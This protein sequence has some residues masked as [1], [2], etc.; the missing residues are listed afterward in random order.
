MHNKA[1]SDRHVCLSDKTN[2]IKTW[3]SLPKQKRNLD[4]LLNL[5]H[6]FAYC[7]IMHV[8]GIE[9][10]NTI[11]TK[12]NH[13]IISLQKLFT[14]GEKKLFRVLLAADHIKH[15]AGVEKFYQP[16]RKLLHEIILGSARLVMTDREYR[17][18]SRRLYKIFK[19]VPG[20]GL[21]RI[22]LQAQ[23]QCGKT[24]TAVFAVYLI[25]MFT[26]VPPAALF[27][28][29]ISQQQSSANKLLDRIQ[30][31]SSQFSSLIE[32]NP[33]LLGTYFGIGHS[34]NSGEIV[35]PRSKTN[36]K[37]ISGRG[38]QWEFRALPNSADACRSWTPYFTLFDEYG[39]SDEDVRSVVAGYMNHH[40]RSFV[41]ITTPA[42]KLSHQWYI[43]QLQIARDSQSR[44][45]GVMYLHER[46]LICT[47]CQRHASSTKTCLHC[48]DKFVPWYT[49]WN[50]FRDLHSARSEKIVE[51]ITVERMGVMYTKTSNCFDSTALEEIRDGSI[52]LTQLGLNSHISKDSVIYISVD[53]PSHHNSY[54][55]LTAFTLF[56]STTGARQTIVLGTLEMVAEHIE[57]IRSDWDKFETKDMMKA[58]IYW[59][60]ASL[61]KGPLRYLRVVPIIEC[62]NSD[63]AADLVSSMFK[64]ILKAPLFKDV[65][66]DTDTIQCLRR[67]G[68]CSKNGIK[69]TAHAKIKWVDFFQ[70]YISESVKARIMFFLD[71]P[72]WHGTNVV[73][74]K[75]AAYLICSEL[76]CFRY[77][78]K[79]QVE[80]NN[81]DGRSD[82]AM[83]I[84][85]GFYWGW[86]IQ[87]SEILPGSQ[88]IRKRKY[89]CA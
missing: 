13:P 9:F 46:C 14:S 51:E 79:R 4:Y 40:M 70:M 33:S 61:L 47:D 22:L 44:G 8:N 29:I 86:M 43:D 45:N 75:D 34:L 56:T 6:R 67:I 85:F 37:V 36:M 62:Q 76:K 65:F 72:Y 32:T 66:K 27:G 59:W 23:R 49:I 54:F 84:M 21:Q 28:V 3:H 71:G 73:S 48:L 11:A 57:G 15:F 20:A 31:Y 82:L 24:E 81:P 39:F 19:I 5:H 30:L 50:L 55:A 80:S 26:I 2:L 38:V 17:E 64:S 83:T 7:F 63:F 1:G 12:I 74:A 18:C 88:N 89:I 35:L 42:V 68:V 10:K 25:S 87:H 78:E 60:M 77:N 53:P 69:T 16:N 41:F 58:S 52:M